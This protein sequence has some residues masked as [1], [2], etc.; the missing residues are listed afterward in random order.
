MIN[1]FLTGRKI[2]RIQERYSIVYEKWKYHPDTSAQGLLRCD[3]QD[4]AHAYD[5]LAEK[6]INPIPGLSSK[7]L[8]TKGCVSQEENGI[9]DLQLVSRKLD[10]LGKFDKAERQS[11]D[12]FGNHLRLLY[13]ER[14]NT[15]QETYKTYLAERLVEAG[16]AGDMDLSIFTDVGKLDYY[17]TKVLVHNEFKWKP[18]LC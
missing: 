13:L 15:A 4:L 9:Q 10:F 2:K 11:L 12:G 8:E 5:M 7:F 14:A 3:L 1:Q 18:I 16:Y 17:V 6:P